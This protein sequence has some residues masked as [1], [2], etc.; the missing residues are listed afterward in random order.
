M[1]TG[2]WQ[3]MLARRE[4]GESS[5]QRIEKHIV[6]PDVT[7]SNINGFK[8]CFPTGGRLIS[9]QREG[10]SE[11]ATGWCCTS[12]SPAPGGPAGARPPS[13]GPLLA[14]SRPRCNCASEP[15]E[16]QSLVAKKKA[17]KSRIL[18]LGGKLGSLNSPFHPVFHLLLQRCC[19]GGG[20][21]PSTLGRAP[22]GGGS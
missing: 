20:S 14:H 17:K 8:G 1:G 15:S 12:P 5:Q 19:D 11:G 7:G 6:K 16:G 13:R 3:D 2:H 9:P 21:A 18:D 10:V 4:G 22:H